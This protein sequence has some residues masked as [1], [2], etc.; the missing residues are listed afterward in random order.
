[1]SGDWVFLV[2]LPIRDESDVVMARKRARE[3]GAKEGMR[4]VAIEALATAISEVARNVVVHAVGGGELLL[5]LVEHA[6]RRGVVVVARD[7]GPGIEDPTQALTE[8][9]STAGSLGLGLSS[10]K[11]LVDEFDLVSTR[12]EGTTVTMKKWIG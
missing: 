9:Y 10:A 5:G 7:A 2:R 3:L 12:G 8:G 11:R 6:D 1:M 4:E